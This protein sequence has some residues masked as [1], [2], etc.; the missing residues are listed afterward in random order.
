[1]QVQSEP[2][3]A[4]NNASAPYCEWRDAELIIT[5]LPQGK[6]VTTRKPCLGAEGLPPGSSQISDQPECLSR[7]ST[8][9]RLVN[10][11]GTT[12]DRWSSSLFE[13]PWYCRST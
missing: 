6:V 7:I 8:C 10:G 12:I 3:F 1:M 9:E 5:I 2:R 11:P 4:R 13:T